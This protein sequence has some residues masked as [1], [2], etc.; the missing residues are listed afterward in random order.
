MLWNANILHKEKEMAKEKAK[1]EETEVDATE[2]VEVTD[3]PEVGAD[4]TLEPV[5]LQIADLQGL[6]QIIDLAFKRGAFAANEAAVIG[7]AYNKLNAFLGYVASQQSLA[8][9]EENADGEE[10]TTESE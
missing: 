4:A 1:V 5:Q 6:G 2:T 10:A 7:T 9:G 8:K 3:A